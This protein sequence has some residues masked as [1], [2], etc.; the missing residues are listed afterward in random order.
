MLAHIL[1]LTLGVLS[2]FVIGI[3]RHTSSYFLERV[4]KVLD[5]IIL[6]VPVCYLA[7]YLFYYFANFCHFLFQKGYL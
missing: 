5:I 2:L 3:T 4:S 7:I 6:L 1:L